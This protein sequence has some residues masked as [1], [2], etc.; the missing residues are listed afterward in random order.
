MSNGNTA[1]Y[2][3]RIIPRY[4]ASHLVA[5]AAGGAAYSFA[6][7][8]ESITLIARFGQFAA[9]ALI[10]A[11]LF[12]LLVLLPITAE[13]KR[14]AVGEGVIR[15]GRRRICVGDVGEVIALDGKTLSRLFLI[16]WKVGDR[17][18]GFS[19]KI[20]TASTREAV[21]IHDTSYVRRPW[22][23]IDVGDT[24]AF[25]DAVNQAKE[26]ANGH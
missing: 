7:W 14:I 21:L 23:V 9:G 12:G 17:D 15:V 26:S 25:I 19:R 2:F 4:S 6:S 20:I 5:C 16:E 22:W 1:P 13:G 8:G 18:I 24:G 10:V 11:A 3:S